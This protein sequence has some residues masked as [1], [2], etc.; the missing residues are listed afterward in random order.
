MYVLII[1]VIDEVIILDVQPFNKYL[2]ILFGLFIQFV[3][4]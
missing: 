1:V 4:H 2:W 3:Q